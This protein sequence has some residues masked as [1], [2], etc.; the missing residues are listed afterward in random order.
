MLIDA[1]LQHITVLHGAQPRTY[2]F[3]KYNMPLAQL[4]L[5]L[6]QSLALESLNHLL[7]ST[8]FHFL[9]HIITSNQPT[10]QPASQPVTMDRSIVECNAIRDR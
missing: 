7:Q 8:A 10:N 9:G 3:D 5:A 6:L 1:F 2:P 4:E